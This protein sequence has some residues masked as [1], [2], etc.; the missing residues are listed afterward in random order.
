VSIRLLQLLAINNFRSKTASKV[1]AKIYGKTVV[2]SQESLIMMTMLK[3]KTVFY[4]MGFHTCNVM[5]LMVPM[6]SVV[7]I[8]SHACS[9]M[10]L[11][12]LLI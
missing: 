12:Y 6:I 1:G 9:T 8:K 11:L 2:A 4:A 3:R 5:K 10:V 7:L